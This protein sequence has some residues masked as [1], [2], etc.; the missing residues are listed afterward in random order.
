MEIIID[1]GDNK[2]IKIMSSLLKM[3]DEELRDTFKYKKSDYD[4]ELKFKSNIVAK[5]KSYHPMEGEFYSYIYRDFNNIYEKCREFFDHENEN[6]LQIEIPFT[7]KDIDELNKKIE[8]FKSREHYI[9]SI[10]KLNDESRKALLIKGFDVISSEEKL[11]EFL[12]KDGN[13]DVVLELSRLIGTIK[14]DISPENDI[15]KNNILYPKELERYLRLRNEINVD[16]EMLGDSIFGEEGMDSYYEN[17][18]KEIDSSWEVN[19]ELRNYIFD[20]MNPN[21]SSEEK[22]SHIYIKMCKLFEYDVSF[23]N[24]G[25]HTGFSKVNQEAISPKNNRIMCA[26]FA[27]LFTKLA[28]EISGVEARCIAPTGWGH[29]AVGLL[30]KEDCIR[31]DLEAINVKGDFNDLA[32]AKLGMPL[33]GIEYIADRKGVFKDAFDGVYE[34]MKSRDEISTENFVEAYENLDNNSLAQIDF[35]RNMSEFLNRANNRIKGNEV[36][37]SYNYLRHLGYF[38]ELNSYFVRRSKD[39]EVT[40]DIIIIKDGEYYYLKTDSCEI[41]KADK[42]ILKSQIKSGE[43]R[44]VDEK[45]VDKNLA[46]ERESTTDEI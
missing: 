10:N 42:E 25:L 36:I 9:D 40:E 6:S 13:K 20:G 44:F 5:Y 8:S 19:S 24:D 7:L 22:I 35:E 41:E 39:K 32:R 37:V 27:R 11:E 14:E 1:N 38:G 43:I 2:E 31:V 12:Q 28:N 15:V 26:E 21:Y 18:Q 33:C 34:S 16:I 46:K 4:Y 30:F 17:Q 45:H 23:E 3:S 29:E